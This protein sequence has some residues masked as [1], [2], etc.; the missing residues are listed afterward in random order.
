M[1]KGL[2]LRMTRT[3]GATLVFGLALGMAGHAV[4][5]ELSAPGEPPPPTTLSQHWDMFD[6]FCVKCHN[7]T[8][9]A[10]KIAFDTMTPEQVPENQTV[11]E[12]AIRKLR[13]GLMPPPGNPR[14]ATDEIAAVATGLA[15]YLDQ[16][17]AEQGP[18]PGH[19]GLHRLNRTEYANAIR[20]LLDVTIDAT[21][22]L[23]RDNAEEG[24]DN[25]ASA[26]QVSPTFLEQYVSA[27]QQVATMAIGNPTANAGSA[28]YVNNGEE[29][30]KR[31][32]EGLPL[33]TRGGMAVIHDFPADG[34]YMINI[35]DMAQAL[36]V[37]NMEFENTVVVTV[38]GGEVYRTTI[39]GDADQKA[40]DQN[41]VSAADEINKRLKNIRFKAKAGQRQVGIAFLART[42]A[43][44]D[45]QLAPYV[46]GG[47]QDRLLKVTSF[48]LRGPFDATGVSDTRSRDKIFSC[49][50]E[51][52][53][54]MARC[55]REIVSHLAHGAYRRPVT[56]G[57]MAD[58][59]KFYEAGKTESGFDNGVRM[60]L[61]AILASP[62]FLFRTATPPAQVA[63]SGIYPLSD[64]DLASQ[65]SF[66]LWSSI[67]DGELL[68]AAE[69]GKLHDPAVLKAE[70]M[71]MLADPKSKSLATNFAFHWLDMD[72][73][74]EIEP[75]GRLFPYAAAGGA[76][77]EDGD[78]RAAYREELGLFID[79][80]FRPD[81]PVLDLLNADWTYVNE[82][83]ALL[84]GIND[85]RGDQ[86]RRVTLTDP[87][88]FGLLGKGAVLLATSDPNRT[89]PVLRG[90]FILENFFGAPPSPPPG[91]V[92]TDL[93]EAKPGEK[94]HTVRELM[95]QHRTDQSCN[96]CHG[97]M[98][99]LGLALENFDAV[100]QWRVKDRFSGTSIDASGQLSD[101]TPVNSP[102]D[103]RA[104]LMR[105]PEL[106]V[107]TFI[108]ELMK[109]GLG[110]T[111]QYYDMP[112]VRAI[113]RAA[114]R[115][116][117]K[118]SS[119][120][121]G[122]VVSDAFQ[123]RKLPDDSVSPGVKQA[124]AKD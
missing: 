36:W 63:A 102:E 115:D 40:I 16:I 92:K 35:A 89:A 85:V 100:G 3:A 45:S 38:D 75:D 66:F 30:Y 8:D 21:T 47:G 42:F 91:T 18:N 17:A 65:L 68:A 54:E 60:A 53:A 76:R 96:M 62:D 55:A 83:V 4:A 87:A 6:K 101:G 61:T 48:E 31:H 67:P 113:V 109:F 2:T 15:T 97:V 51:A 74:A 111:L 41:G 10:G 90:K 7:F 108:E 118:F 33:G 119:I 88:R 37:Y 28:T 1:L 59:I 26:L 43:E 98:D 106:F 77:T 104:A 27:A 19:V 112:E 80:V 46:P 122:I 123:M 29:S 70:V 105:N 95:A 120:V 116:D 58:L 25:M 57:D 69:A 56:D 32:V 121:M 107:Q 14:P 5:A 22:L 11:F 117:Y 99:P 84:Y 124:S 103:V 24:Y 23:P 12:T 94:P 78:P 64:I 52:E 73:L 72:R 114:A 20:D 13:G 44:S 93:P 49:Y 81:R 34:E 9:W 79:S 86:F 110:R 50:P 71:R 82:R 39:G